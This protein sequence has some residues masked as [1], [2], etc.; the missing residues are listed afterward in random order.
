MSKNNTKAVQAGILVVNF[1]CVIITCYI[2]DMNKWIGNDKAE[3]QLQDNR[4]YQGFWR[5][6]V[7][8]TMAKES[9]CDTIR[10]WFFSPNLPSWVISGR[11]MVGFAI[12]GGFMSTIGFLLGSEL[13]TALK[14]STKQLVKR[15]SGISMV[16]NGGLLFTTGIWIFVLVARSYNA[17]TINQ[18]AYGCEGC[19]SGTNLVP[20]RA[21]YG[22]IALGCIGIVNGLVATCFGKKYDEY[23]QANENY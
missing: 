14:S 3:R 9:T 15:A 16:I 13:S 11:L 4:F 5:K 12:L 22:A 23:E 10:E 19:D 20:S 6:C 21:T 2:Y 1:I 17:R 18:I 8:K 7:Y